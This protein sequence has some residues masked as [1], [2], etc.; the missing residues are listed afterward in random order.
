MHALGES[1]WRP[2]PQKFPG[3]FAL[4]LISVDGDPDSDAIAGPM[5]PTTYL[6]QCP[7]LLQVLARL[8]AVWGRTRLMKLTGGAEVTPHA[9]I[10]YY[11]RD[12]MRVHVPILTQPGVRFICGE[13]EVN[14]APG[15]CWIFDTWRPHRVINVADHERVHLVADTVGGEAFWELAGR[16]RAPG[17]GDSGGWRTDLFEGNDAGERPSLALESSNTPQ[18]MTPW[19]LRNHVEFILSHV[20]PHPQLGFVQQLASRFMANWHA[21]WA[22]YG[23]DRAGWPEYRRALDEFAGRMERNAVPLQLVNG[24]QFMSTLRSMVLGVALADGRGLTLPNEPRAPTAPGPRVG[25]TAGDPQFDRPVFLV[26][27]PRSGSTLLF[28]TLARARNVYTI[29]HESH[30]LIE[31]VPGLSARTRSFDSNRLV[32]EDATEEV[33]NELRRRFHGELRDRDARPPAYGAVRMLE[34][35]PKNSLRVPF[36]ARA[37]P[38]AIFVYLYRDPRQTLASMLEAW[39]SGRFRTYAD[40]PGW[41][42]P[43]WSLLLTPGWQEL[44]GKPLNAIVAAQWEATTRTLLDDIEAM[45]PERCCVARYDALLRE[46]QQEIGR[47]CELLGFEWDQPPSRE[48]PRSRHTVSE[49]DPDKWLRR[50]AEIEA[51]LP[52]IAETMERAE[53]FTALEDAG[54]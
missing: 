47:L 42:G 3:N 28:E 50:R 40:L 7:Y 16:G 4:P 41:D 43:P 45:D 31:G 53:R 27:P 33:V 5:R 8:G 26:S 22:Q 35:T 11:W 46:P 49:P 24:M 19:E 54:A 51:V 23:E 25:E 1:A 34:K 13:A 10:N 44:A 9:D 36:L 2:H 39:E 21:L 12:R 29:G 17:F 18:V 14:M 6:E 15:E 37:F 30:A 48:L 52:A 38:E 32:A 20:V